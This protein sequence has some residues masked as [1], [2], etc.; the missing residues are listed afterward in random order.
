MFPSQEPTPDVVVRPPVPRLPIKGIQQDALSKRIRG[1]DNVDL[2]EPTGAGVFINTN[3]WGENETTLRLKQIDMIQKGC[4]IGFSGWHNF[5]IMAQRN[6][7]RGIICD[8]NP[9]NALFL[10]HV[11]INLRASKNRLDFIQNI[12]IYI[13]AYEIGRLIR[14]RT[15]LTLSISFSPNVKDDPIY[16]NWTHYADEV[17]V[18]LKRE[19][20]WLF[21]DERFEHIKKLAMT[22]KIAL[23]TENILA[24]K[25]FVQIA[26]LLRDNAEQIDTVYISN[27]AHYIA[28][29]DQESFIKTIQALSSN[30]ET[31]LID[32]I[33]GKYASGDLVQRVTQV[34]VLPQLSLQQLFFADRSVIQETQPSVPA[35]TAQ[36]DQEPPSYALL[37]DPVPR[38]NPIVQPN[39]QPNVEP[40]NE[41]DP[42]VPH[43]NQARVKIMI[44]IIDKICFN[45]THQSNGRRTCSNFKHKVNLLKNIKMRLQGMEDNNLLGDAENNII[46]EMR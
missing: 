38:N 46:Q 16:A 43:D 44:A 30:K 10:H 13:E 5:D 34:G 39:I 4:H 11:L 33:N 35:L 8:L 12:K 21:Y 17:D 36:S 27:I 37:N 6:S 28:D 45:I 40:V 14:L 41:P 15:D 20:S 3:E 23:I 32:A 19:T 26:N 31:I 9:E 42:I 2:K 29:K 24:S 1:Y 7:A 25:T 18:E 22:D